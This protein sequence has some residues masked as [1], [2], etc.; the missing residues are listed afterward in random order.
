MSTPI[1]AIHVASWNGSTWKDLGNGATTGNIHKGTVQTTA[2]VTSFNMFTLEHDNA[3]SL[4]GRE[5]DFSWTPT[6]TVWAEDVVTFENLS[7][8]FPNHYQYVWIVDDCLIPG[9]C[10]DTLAVSSD[11]VRAFSYG[12]YSIS[13]KAINNGGHIVGEKTKILKVFPAGLLDCNCHADIECDFVGNG[14]FTSRYEDPHNLNEIANLDCWL[15]DPD[16]GENYEGEC[17]PLEFVCD[18]Y[19]HDYLP[20]FCVGENSDA[21]F[22]IPFNMYTSGIPVYENGATT[23][24][25]NSSYAVVRTRG[26]YGY[27]IA[28]PHDYLV[29]NLLG[30]LNT[31]QAYT[32]SLDARLS[33]RSA[34]TSRINIGLTND[35][36][37]PASTE[38]ET[39]YSITP[40]DLPGSQILTF[41]PNYSSGFLF[42]YTSWHHCETTFTASDDYTWM[43]IGGIFP[44]G[45][46][47]DVDG[48]YD[49]NGGT[50]VPFT[51]PHA[52]YNWPVFESRF[53]IDNV[54]LQALPPTITQGTGLCRTGSPVTINVSGSGTG[55][56]IYTWSASPSD[57]S[58]TG[59][60]HDMEIEVNPSAATTTYTVT[61]QGPDGCELTDQIIV[62]SDYCCLPETGTTTYI[63]A[64]LTGTQVLSGDFAINGIMNIEPGAN[65]TFN[66]ANVNMGPN[67]EIFVNSSATLSITNSSHIQSCTDMWDQITVINGATLVVNQGSQI[68][69]AEIAI[70]MQDGVAFTIEDAIFN[71]NFVHINVIAPNTS[72]VYAATTFKRNKFLCQTQASIITPP[73]VHTNLKAPL[74]A[75]NTAFGI[76][77]V[78]IRGLSVGIKDN[79]NLFENNTYGIFANDVNAVAVMDNDFVE[80]DANAM[81]IQNCGPSGNDIDILENNILKT[82]FGIIC[83]DN[84][85]A[86]IKI[87]DNEIDF[88]GMTSPPT[89]MT[90]IWVEEITPGT[91]SN[92]NLVSIANN[93]IDFAPCGIHAVNLYGNVLTPST[94][95]GNNT[96][97]TDKVPNDAQAGILAQNCTGLMINENVVSNGSTSGYE[98]GIRVSSGNTNWLFCNPVSDINKGFIFDNDLRPSTIMVKNVMDNNQ[99]GIFLNYA[100]IGFQ[101]SSTVGLDNE[102]PGTWSSSNPNTEVYGVGILGSL[103]KFYVQNSTPYIPTENNATGGST[104]PIPVSTATGP[105]TLGCTV[106]APSYKT[107]GSENPVLEEA[108]SMLSGDVEIETERM[109]SIRWSGEY[110]LYKQLL[111]DEELRYSNASLLDFY[112]EKDNSNVGQLHRALSRFNASRNSQSAADGVIA[113]ALGQLQTMEP[114]YRTEERLKE[115]L[116]ILYTNAADL[117]TMN[118]EHASRLREIAQLC[119]LD[120]GF[121]V[122]IARSALLKLDTLPRSYQS[123]CERN[124]SD[125]YLAEKNETQSKEI[126]IYPNPSNGSF[127]VTYSLQENE[128]GFI[129]VIDAVGKRVFLV[130]LSANSSNLGVTF[131]GL[132]TGLYFITVRINEELKYSDKLVVLRK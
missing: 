20:D 61:V 40:T 72:P 91:Y 30:G 110:G 111:S 88:T 32:V 77:A 94:Y 11:F 108:L 35:Y 97:T 4:C 44:F 103:S 42:G 59:Q 56:N 55:T 83:Y 41:T 31:G 99:T 58:L 114:V 19:Q 121:G 1:S 132:D 60:T 49:E 117:A 112:H 9:Y 25:E 69:D 106:S 27:S 7:V 98:A 95:I 75:Y 86:E 50:P 18:D 57:A 70:V 81:Y 38:L 129:E 128:I 93:I 118:D 109:R 14:S 47:D 85:E 119:P 10:G 101:G 23:A 67:A 24:D 2:A 89:E 5:V 45:E 22:S 73:A 36:I 64:T 48:V 90:G 107:E 79:G 17:V 46:N 54:S 80:M 122:Y 29:N 87:E 71:R 3:M 12:I 15:R 126:V 100:I 26:G 76:Y 113:E 74:A 125:D 123:E 51:Y 37:C 120:E 62:S 92:P 65:I 28:F 43:Y 6:D 13:L 21:D 127:N 53:F 52:G 39:Y 102:W 130:Q 63:N 16:A 131:D 68:E 78:N 84:P 82:P 96:I 8:N 116:T 124:P 115:V 104:D 66:A 34:V 105:S 33:N